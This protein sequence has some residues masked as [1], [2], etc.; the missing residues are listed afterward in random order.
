MRTLVSAN[1]GPAAVRRNA[2]AAAMI[3]TKRMVDA[4][5]W[6]GAVHR[7]YAPGGELA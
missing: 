2:T 6:D 4:P 5:R 1:A 3:G 7:V